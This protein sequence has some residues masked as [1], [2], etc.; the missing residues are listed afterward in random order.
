MVKFPAD[1]K[2]HSAIAGSKVIG[3]WDTASMVI[4]YTTLMLGSQSGISKL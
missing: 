3:S 4:V 2:L 1:V